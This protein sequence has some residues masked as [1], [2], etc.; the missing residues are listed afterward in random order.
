MTTSTKQKPFELWGLTGG[1][2]SGKTTV[3]GLFEEAG[4]PVLDADRIS[5]DLSVPGGAAHDAILK[6]FG[7]SD[8]AKLRETVFKDPEA[9]R[10]L[11]NLLH[12]LIAQ[13]SLKRAQALA[14][15]VNRPR[16]VILYEAAL[17]VET[18]RHK[19]LDGLIVVA[20]DPALR[21]KRLS[22]RDAMTAEMADRM[23]AAQISE[24][25]RKKHAIYVIENH[26]DL[27]E[28]RQAV[29]TAIVKLGF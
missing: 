29:Q 26:G 28:L 2:A 1:I 12:P 11:E 20:S 10:D 15:Q 21:K 24:E 14:A 7:T 6:R 17:L 27:E 22:S 13:E 19:D 23:I 3:A 25:E 16:R 9:R 5:R 8:R 4:I 18:A